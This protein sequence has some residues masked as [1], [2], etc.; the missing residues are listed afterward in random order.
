MI[1]HSDLFRNPQPH[2]NDETEGR[3][4][5]IFSRSKYYYPNLVIMPVDNNEQ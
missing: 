3:F 2:Y 5:K 1:K 4:N